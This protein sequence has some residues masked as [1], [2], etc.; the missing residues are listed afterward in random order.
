MKIGSLREIFF[1]KNM[2]RIDNWKWFTGDRLQVQ[3]RK[4]L[5]EDSSG[6]ARYTY[7]IHSYQPIVGCSQHPIFTWSMRSDVV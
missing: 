7:L 1:K 5:M 2:I 3:V 4:R 6:H